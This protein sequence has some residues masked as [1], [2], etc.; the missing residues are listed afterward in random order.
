MSHD[1]IRLLAGALEEHSGRL[2]STN[3]HELLTRVVEETAAICNE[4]GRELLAGPRP[5]PV[6]T[7]EPPAPVPTA[8]ARPAPS[9]S[10][11]Q[12]ENG[13]AMSLRAPDS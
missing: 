12:T 9:Q 6:P 5:Q 8:A 13:A 1:R 2:E 10:Q 11:Q 3:L 4:V 7:A